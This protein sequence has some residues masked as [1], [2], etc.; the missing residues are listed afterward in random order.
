MVTGK[1]AFEGKSQASLIAAIM[2]AD[3]PAKSSL[4]VM[5]S[6]ALDQIVKTCLAKDPDSR[7]HS[8]GDVERQLKWM[9]E[10][11]SQPSVAAPV[12]A[13]APQRARWRLTVAV[14]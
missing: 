11:G 14:A 5:F 8:A 7:W 12:V 2:H 10:G 1:K 13:T 4:Q 9:I 6:P 3:P